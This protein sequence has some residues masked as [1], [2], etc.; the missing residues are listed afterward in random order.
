MRK[1]TASGCPTAVRRPVCPV[2]KPNKKRPRPQLIAGAS[3]F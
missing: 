1:N 3:A 2:E